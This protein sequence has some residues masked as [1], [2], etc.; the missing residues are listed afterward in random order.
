MP[1][2]QI[3]PPGTWVK[4]KGN[5]FGYV[6]PVAVVVEHKRNGGMVLQTE[7]SDEMHVMRY[8]V[9][10]MRTPPTKRLRRLRHQLPYGKW[11]YADG[12][13]VLFNRNY[14]PIWQR[15]PGQ[16]AEAADPEERVPFERQKWFYTDVNQ[17]WRNAETDRLCNVILSSWNLPTV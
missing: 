11:T 16:A 2:S 3:V 10:V 7:G 12:R 9:T 13:E 8:E 17:P 5:P 1:S 6:H 15:R 4:F 14:K